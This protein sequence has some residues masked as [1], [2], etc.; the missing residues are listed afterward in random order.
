M[1]ALQVHLIL[2]HFYMYSNFDQRYCQGVVTNKD[3]GQVFWRCVFIWI[4]YWM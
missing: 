1:T 4:A 3:L 2:S